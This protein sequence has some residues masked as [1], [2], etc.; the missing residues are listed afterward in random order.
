MEDHGVLDLLAVQRCVA[1][2]LVRLRAYPLVDDCV[3][4]RT[5]TEFSVV[6]LR[7]TDA[8]ERHRSLTF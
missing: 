1:V 5:E 7:A 6:T 8:K 4:S 2:Q 3:S